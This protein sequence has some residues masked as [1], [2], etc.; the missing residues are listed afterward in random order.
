MLPGIGAFIGNSSMTM[1]SRI[2]EGI[3]VRRLLQRVDG[4]AQRSIGEHAAVPISL[5]VDLGHRK[6]GRKAATGSHML[7]R[8]AI[9]TTAV[10]ELDLARADVGDPHE[11]ASLLVVEH[12]RIHQLVERPSQR[13]GVVDARHRPW[14]H[15][16]CGV[17][18]VHTG[19]AEGGQRLINLHGKPEHG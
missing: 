14:R 7:E 4:G 18:A 16:H 12:C 5:P 6:A 13:C 8:Q 3:A 9:A 17:Q 2:A 19:I 15:E 11:D 10:E 1:S